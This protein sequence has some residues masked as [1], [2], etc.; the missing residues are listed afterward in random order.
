MEFKNA[1][2]K[3]EALKADL[4]PVMEKFNIDVLIIEDIEYEKK[5]I[6]EDLRK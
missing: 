5:G 6:I 1:Y 3:D 2:E 4:L